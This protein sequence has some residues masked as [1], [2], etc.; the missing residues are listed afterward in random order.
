MTNNK[1]NLSNLYYHLGNRATGKTTLLQTGIKN[2]DKPFLFVCTSTRR[3]EFETDKNEEVYVKMGVSTVSSEN[4][5]ENMIVEIPHW[6]FDM[7]KKS[8]ENKWNQELSK[9]NIKR[10]CSLIVYLQRFCSFCTRSRNFY[11]L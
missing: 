10:Q 5:L 11:N 3:G 1:L 9:I 7:V 2:Y 6:D 4:A 8:A